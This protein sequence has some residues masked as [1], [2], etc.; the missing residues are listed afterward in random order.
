[1]MLFSGAM[2]EVVDGHFKS[3]NS[4]VASVDLF[5]LRFQQL[6]QLTQLTFTICCHCSHVIKVCAKLIQRRVYIG[7]VSGPSC[8]M[9]YLRR[10]LLSY[11]KTV[12]LS[13]HCLLFRVGVVVYVPVFSACRNP[14]L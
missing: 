9:N 11:F 14:N 3:L 6:H 7:N 10:Q 4:S 8:H 12:Y 2:L 5:M 1:M 13:S